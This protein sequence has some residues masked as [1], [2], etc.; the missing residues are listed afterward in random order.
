MN[1]TLRIIILEE[2]TPASARQD[3]FYRIN[4]TGVKAN[5]SEIRRGSYLGP[6]TTF[7]EKCSMDPLFVSLCPMSKERVD[8]HE[9]FEFVLRF[10]AYTNN[11]ENFKHTVNEFLDAYLVQNLDTFDEV[12]FHEE[13]QGMLDFVKAYFPFGFAKSKNAKSTPR[14]RFEAISVGVALA[15]RKKKSL[16]VKNIEWINS[17]KF[18]EITTSDASNNEGRLKERVEYVR[19]QLLKG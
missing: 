16:K 17:K 1:K 2:D 5:D 9:R 18:K 12:L 7:I 13:F 6:L 19:D 11:Y 8:R 10:F 4:T 15:L 3:L 14:V